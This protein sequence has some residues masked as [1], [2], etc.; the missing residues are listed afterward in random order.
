MLQLHAER[1]IRKKGSNLQK[2][3]ERMAELEKREADYKARVEE[4][5]REVAKRDEMISFTSRTARVAR[6]KFGV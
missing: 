5:E 6:H 1:G 4:L 3:G 2:L